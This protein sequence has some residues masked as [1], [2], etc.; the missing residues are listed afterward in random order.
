MANRDRPDGSDRVANAGSIPEPDAIEFTKFRC[1]ISLPAHEV[2]PVVQAAGGLRR[3]SRSRRWR[4]R[5]RA[6]E[7]RLPLIVRFAVTA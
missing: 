2:A 7:T 4:S 6:G 3:C 5:H 1:T